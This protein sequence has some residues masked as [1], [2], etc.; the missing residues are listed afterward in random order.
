MPPKNESRISGSPQPRRGSSISANTGPASPSAQSS[1]PTTSTLGAARAGRLLARAPRTRRAPPV[2]RA[3]GHVDEEDPAPGRVL[4]EPA[5]AERPD[6]ERDAGPRRPRADRGAALLAAERRRDHGEPGRGEDR[7]G[8]ALQAARE[9]QASCRRAPRRRGSRRARTT[10]CRSG[11]AAGR[12]RGRR[13]SRRRGAASRASGGR[14]RRPTAGARARRRGRPGSPAT[15]RSRPW[16]RRTRSPNRGC[17]PR[18]PGDCEFRATGA[19]SSQTRPS[20]QSGSSA[21][22]ASSL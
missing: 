10:R 6:H 17:K 4:D 12:R 5:A 18:G 13:A 19:R 1:P 7:A 20:W 14:R 15:P 22:L 9:D 8:G 2:T 16:S 3:N 21:G 11:R